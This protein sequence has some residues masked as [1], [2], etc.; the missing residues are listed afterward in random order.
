[1][2]LSDVLVV[3]GLLVFSLLCGWYANKLDRE[4]AAKKALDN[5]FEL[6]YNYSVIRKEDRFIGCFP[7]SNTSEEEHKEL[8]KLTE[9]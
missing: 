1:M 9:V 8:D 6:C 5:V 7:M 3:A 4:D 2:K